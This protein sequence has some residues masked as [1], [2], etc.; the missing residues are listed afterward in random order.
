MESV[1]FCSLGN[2]SVD[3]AHKVTLS[4]DP[5]AS[6]GSVTPLTLSVTFLMSVFF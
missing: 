6:R 2:L 1:L 5:V 3:H 4:L